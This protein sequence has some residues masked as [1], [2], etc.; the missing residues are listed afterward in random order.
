M[1]CCTQRIDFHATYWVNVR[2]FAHRVM[3]HRTLSTRRFGRIVHGIGLELVTTMVGT[4]VVVDVTVSGVAGSII[5]S[6]LHA[7]YWIDGVS[8]ATAK[9]VT[10]LC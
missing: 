9:T 2:R 10:I 3:V 4:E 5:D 1:V 8:D 7:T 6:H